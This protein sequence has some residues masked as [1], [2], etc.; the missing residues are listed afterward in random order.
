MPLSKTDHTQC[1][2]VPRDPTGGCRGALV[3]VGLYVGCH[4]LLCG[5]NAAA[6]RSGHALRSGLLAHT[7]SLACQPHVSQEWPPQWTLLQAGRGLGR[8]FSVT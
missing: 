8:S 1:L 6:H 5:L 2:P 3:D 7:S 4:V